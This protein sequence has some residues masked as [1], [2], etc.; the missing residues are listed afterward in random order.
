M[1][2]RYIKE[3]K[4]GLN[5]KRVSSI[6]QHNSMIN[7]LHFVWII[8]MCC[9]IMYVINCI[10]LHCMVLYYFNKYRVWIN[11]IVHCCYI[12][13]HIYNLNDNVQ[14]IVGYWVEVLWKSGINDK[15]EL[16]SNKTKWEESIKVTTRSYHIGRYSK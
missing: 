1:N 14:D 11:C 5:P 9:F 10:V 6:Y 4:K 3:N 2:F 12:I 15:I 8:I 13:S 7:R 16:L